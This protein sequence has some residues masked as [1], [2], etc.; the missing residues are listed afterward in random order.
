MAAYFV[1]RWKGDDSGELLLK[2][3][4][5]HDANEVFNAYKDLIKT[6]E[7]LII[8]LDDFEIKRFEKEVE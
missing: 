2:S 7:D 4:N 6:G 5:L 8:T 1:E 3:D